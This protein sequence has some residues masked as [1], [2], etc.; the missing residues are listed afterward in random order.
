VNETHNP[1]NY[2]YNHDYPLHINHPSFIMAINKFHLAKYNYG[3]YCLLVIY[4]IFFY[5]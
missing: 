4:I 2:Q 1:K 3:K 5:L